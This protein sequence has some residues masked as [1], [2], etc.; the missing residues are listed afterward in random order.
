MSIKIK[1]FAVACIAALSMSAVAGCSCGDDSVD[2]IKAGASSDYENTLQ[3]DEF[4]YD[5]YDSFIAIDEYIGSGAVCEIPEEI[6]GKPVTQINSNAFYNTDET[7]E[8]VVIPS[9]VTE[10]QTNAF[11]ANKLQQIEIDEE[12]SNF[13]IDNGVL[14]NVEK[15]QLLAFPGESE[16]EEVEISE[17]VEVIPSG[18]FSNCPNLKRVEIP[19]TV[20][21]IETFAF[22]GS[23]LTDVKLPEGVEELGMGVFWGCVNLET[24]ELP[25]SLKT[26]SSPETVCQGCTSLKTVK[27]YD[28]T[29][30]GKIIDAD[31]L[32]AEYV[33]LG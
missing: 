2:A 26:I 31:G 7:L 18:V 15:T 28:S 16:I 12:N 6:D 17:G 21:Q 11:G 27:G 8:R 29:D 1:L 25:Q 9:T 19:S 33:S 13:V 22:M 20:K 30:A 4:Q 24:L 3:S 32:Q 5:V 14:M 23:G 10:I